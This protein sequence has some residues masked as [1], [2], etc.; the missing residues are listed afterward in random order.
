MFNGMA[1]RFIMQLYEHYSDRV[2]NLTDTEEGELSA[3]M[4]ALRCQAWQYMKAL[5]AILRDRNAWD[6]EKRKPVWR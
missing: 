1:L 6:Y 2:D 3:E 5:I 4:I